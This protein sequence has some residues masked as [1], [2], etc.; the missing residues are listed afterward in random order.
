[1]ALVATI[2]FVDA[3]QR[4]APLHQPTPRSAQPITHAA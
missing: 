2:H 1:M 4:G 3:Q